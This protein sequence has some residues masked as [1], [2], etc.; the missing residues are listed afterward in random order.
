M[1]HQPSKVCIRYFVSSN[2]ICALFLGAF[3]AF[4]QPATTIQLNVLILIM[5]RL[6]A[7]SMDMSALFST[8]CTVIYIC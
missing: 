8:M 7:S 3:L 2:V 5:L 1:L 4:Y 6:F